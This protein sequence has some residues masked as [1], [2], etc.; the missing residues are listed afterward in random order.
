VYVQGKCSKEASSHSRGARLPYGRADE[1]PEQVIKQRPQA[2]LLVD[3]HLQQ[4]PQA[5]LT[6]FRSKPLQ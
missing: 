1:G 6:I 4:Q 5:Q 2:R 3:R